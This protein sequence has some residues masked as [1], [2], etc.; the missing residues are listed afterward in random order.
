MKKRMLA[1]LATSGAAMVFSFISLVHTPTAVQAEEM[2]AA[3]EML[4]ILRKMDAV[5][6]E[7]YQ[8]LKAKIAAEK[9][10]EAKLAKAIE[11]SADSINVTWKNGPRFATEDGNYQFGFSGRIHQQVGYISNN[12]EIEDA[13]DTDDNFRSFIRRARLGVNGKVYDQ[14]GFKAEYDFAGGDVNFADVFLEAYKV[15]FTGTI[16]VGHFKEPLS[17][18]EMTSTNN[19]WF[20]ERSQANEA[21][22]QG[23]DSG[24]KI[25]NLALDKR[26]G[27]ALALM[28]DVDNAGNG[29]FNNNNSRLVGR[30][31][32][33]PFSKE[34][35]GDLHLGLSYRHL[36]LSDNEDSPNTQ[37]YRSRPETQVTNVRYVDTGIFSA[38]STDLVVAEL[39]WA[40]DRWNAVAEYFLQDVNLDEGDDPTF[41]GAYGLVSYFLTDDKRAYNVSS[42]G[43][44]SVRPKNPFTL[45]GKGTGA[46]EIATRYSY[47]DLDDEDF[48]GGK[49]GILTVGLNW[50]PVDMFSFMLDYSYV[51]VDDRTV[52]GIDL[53]NETAHVVQSRFQVAF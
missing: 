19:N 28:T 32:G 45:E 16:T 48:D 21:F 6:Q 3:E 23:R 40:K 2:S 38:D 17:V 15:P 8:K 26:F 39:A 33:L 25:Q 35:V 20:I 43:F 44:S 31:W 5:D 18:D 53:D 46:W 29:P 41:W 34:E 42:G 7:K 24:I 12:D 30:I 36:E 49:Q 10:Q 13:F 37:R 1:G 52:N 14:F 50:Y 11:K 4:E 51:S 47:L 22:Y 9:E 27:Y